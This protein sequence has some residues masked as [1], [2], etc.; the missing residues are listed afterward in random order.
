MGAR[1]RKLRN[2][3]GHRR[4][5]RKGRHRLKNGQKRRS[6]RYP[7]RS[8][9]HRRPAEL[10]QLLRRADGRKSNQSTA[11]YPKSSHRTSTATSDATADAISDATADAISDAAADATSDATADAISDA[12]AG[13]ISDATAGATS[14]AISDATSTDVF[15]GICV[16]SAEEGAPDKLPTTGVVCHNLWD[17]IHAHAGGRS[18]DDGCRNCWEN[19]NNIIDNS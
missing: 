16:D 17:P 15:P 6:P 9:H 13:A 7:R 4:R 1:L 18:G 5:R 19:L 10:D 8:P 14:T 3:D 11:F 12:T 2:K